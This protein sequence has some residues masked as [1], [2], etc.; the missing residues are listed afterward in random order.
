MESEIRN[1]LTTYFGTYGL[2]M[3]NKVNEYYKVPLP[4]KK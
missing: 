2:I 1:T 4:Q 3:F